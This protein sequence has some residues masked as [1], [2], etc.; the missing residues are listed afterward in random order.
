MPR[1]RRPDQGPPIPRVRA[2]CVYCK[3][4]RLKCSET[5]P[6]LHCVS[7]AVQCLEVETTRRCRRTYHRTFSEDE[8]DSLSPSQDT[9]QPAYNLEDLSHA[10][11]TRTSDYV[12]VDSSTDVQVYSAAAHVDVET[13]DVD[14]PIVGHTS[15]VVVLDKGLRATMDSF[16]EHPIFLSRPSTP[17]T[18]G[19][20]D[21]HPEYRA[22]WYHYT[23]IL[24]CLHTSHEKSSNPIVRVL[25]PVAL[26]SE[27]L[28]A[29][30]LASS[31]ENYRSLRG[32]EPDQEMLASL[33]NKA[34]TGVQLD[35]ERAEDGQVA[36]TTLATVIA[37]CDFEIVARKRAT[38]SS[39]RVH[40]DG[41]KRII[42]LRGGPDQV[43][44]LSELN[45]FL[46]K[47]LAYF[48]IMSSMTSTSI[49]AEPLFQGNYWMRSDYEQTYSVE[50]DV[51]LDPYMGFLQNVVP[52]FLEIGQLTRTKAEFDNSMNLRTA[53]ELYTRC[54]E[55]ENAL[56]TSL[57]S[58]P[59]HDW[60]SETK[61]AV[62]IDC[63]D[64][65]TYS[66][67][68][69][70]YRRVEAIPSQAEDVR[71][72][73]SHGLRHIQNSC[74]GDSTDIDASLL[75]PLFTFGCEACEVKDREFVLD[76]LHALGALGL[77]NVDRAI[78]VLVSVWES[79]VQSPGIEWTEILNMFHWEV[80]LA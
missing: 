66:T 60:M 80:N 34:V 22:L 43:K 76:R 35:L 17:T 61:V 45:K 19:L 24:S 11:N 50:D 51:K 64:A 36:D 3:I 14:L 38:T 78:E 79:Q 71:N 23:E 67:L 42:A 72:A 13:V 10:G 44:A 27:P 46:L 63:H 52:Y 4:K 40:L 12:Q 30:L 28:L 6:C 37:L 49:T 29:V 5:R 77:G 48:D 75:F 70:L 8:I 7:T 73:V 33:I 69:H 74:T 58:I 59:S 53:N 47:W 54:R 65:F 2:A 31:L 55:I 56:L 26:S 32:L 1:K 9:L 15:T 18:L 20:L 41:A 25:A 62:L 39:W 57:G 16:L 68:I 21:S